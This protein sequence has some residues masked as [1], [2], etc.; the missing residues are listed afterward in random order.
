LSFFAYSSSRSLMLRM[1]SIKIALACEM[2]ERGIGGVVNRARKLGHLWP[3][4]G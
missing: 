1:R 4:L 3:S 2:S